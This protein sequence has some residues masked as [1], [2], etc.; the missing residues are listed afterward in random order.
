MISEM[1]GEVS[2]AL[3][4]MV[5][6]FL[7]AETS[8]VE[9]DLAAWV[10]N[11]TLTED[12]FVGCL[13]PMELAK[14]QA[15]ANPAERRHFLARRC[16]QRLFVCLVAGWKFHP[17]TIRLEHKLDSRP[18]CLDFPALQLSFSTSG[19]AAVAC[20]SRTHAVGIDIE[21]VRVIENAVGLATRF[22]TQNEAEVIA[23]KP[24]DAKSH[25]FLMHWTTKEAGLKAIGQG[26]VA[27]L[28]AF[29]LVGEPPRVAY[30][31]LGPSAINGTWTLKNFD[32]LP[33]H[34]I[35]LIE[36]NSVDKY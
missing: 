8:P 5:A 6:D 19:N 15:I 21:R 16:F 33:N 25:H 26:I 23:A 36:K 18:T 22:F 31:V 28:N 3:L 35:A 2:P 13:S 9:V 7:W 24:E 30:T 27:G 32:I 11:G 4:E 14:A 12:D 34:I 20:A 10:D 17:R 1:G 29:R